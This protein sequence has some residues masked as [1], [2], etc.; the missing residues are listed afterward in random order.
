MIAIEKGQRVLLK[1]LA[2]Y[3]EGTFDEYDGRW[4]K[5]GDPKTVFNVGHETNSKEGNWTEFESTGQPYEL[6][7]EDHVVSIRPVGVIK[8]G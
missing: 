7:N 5:L 4:I 2:L 1:T 3:Y 6:L 8:K